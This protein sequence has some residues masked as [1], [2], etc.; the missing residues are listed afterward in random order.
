MAINKSALG[1]SVVVL[2]VLAVVLGVV[3]VFVGPVVIDDQVVK[4]SSDDPDLDPNRGA[5]SQVLGS[6]KVYFNTRSPL[7]HECRCLF[8]INI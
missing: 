8:N 3:L 2:G 5:E 7:I 4:V 1:V 6:S